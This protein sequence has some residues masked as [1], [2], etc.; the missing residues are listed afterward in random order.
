MLL[1][2]LT[3]IRLTYIRFENGVDYFSES[4]ADDCLIYAKIVEDKV[5]RGY[6]LAVP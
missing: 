3:N 1:L 5:L 2:Q 4:V 6:R